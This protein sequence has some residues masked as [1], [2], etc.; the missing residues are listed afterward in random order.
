MDFADYLKEPVSTERPRS[1]GWLVLG[2]LAVPSGSVLLADPVFMLQ[3]APIE[4]GAGSL[5]VEVALSDFGGRRLVS[6]LRASREPGGTPGKGIQRFIVDSRRVGLAD[7]DRFVALA[8]PLDDAGYDA[9]I[10]TPPAEDELAGQIHAQGP[11][12]VVFA[13][14]GFGSGAFLIRELILDG[15]RVGIQVDFANLDLDDASED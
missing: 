11:A 1:S 5:L 12:P 7:V 6:R 4:V 10:A 8:E 13:A 2:R 3:S 9:F 14:T 15:E